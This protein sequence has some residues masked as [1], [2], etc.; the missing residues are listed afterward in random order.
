MS[1]RLPAARGSRAVAAAVLA[2]AALGLAAS[3]A[4]AQEHWPFGLGERAEYAVTF[5]PV[6]VGH[7]SLAVEAADTIRGTPTLRVVMAMRGGTFFY[8]LD[9][10]QTSWIAP[11]PFRSLRFQQH[12]R[13][14]S[15][16]RD[17]VY[18]LDQEAG[19]YRRYDRNEDGRWAPPPGD[20]HLGEGVPMPPAALDEIGF[21]YFARTLPL[22]PGQTYR[23]TR[24]FEAEGNP[25]VLEVLRR[26][27]ITV[28]AG[29]FQTLVV[30]PV[31]RTGGMFG[32]GGN[33]EVYFSDDE[34]RII[35]QLETSMKV[36]RLDLYLEDYR[37][38]AGPATGDGRVAADSVPPLAG[39]TPCR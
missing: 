7:A 22:E 14:G 4:L 17:R 15:Y 19:R 5:G 3:A 11:R 36:G 39:D 10:R 20:E 35:V 2:L 34:R 28:P 25:V 12:L 18:C 13:E 26:E 21:L 37:P 24:Y 30:H 32:E 1:R 6:K 16:R 9:D 33:A 8:T 31:I 29:R 38:A 23:F 27:T